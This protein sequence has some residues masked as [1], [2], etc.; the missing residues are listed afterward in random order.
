MFDTTN[1]VMALCVAG[2]EAEGEPAKARALFEQA[3]AARKG[4]FDA[5][6]AAHFLAR[7]Q[8]TPADTLHW[9][10]VALEHADA[11]RD[12]RV[13][14]L[15]PSLCLNLGDSLLA[16]GRE[17]EA[18]ALVERAESAVA[19]LPTD[20]YGMMVRGGIERL[21]ARVDAAVPEFRQGL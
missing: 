19:A 12:D 17:S 7:Q 13:A 1:P 21:R 18:L 8:P 2:M 6:V 5:S 14:T 20:G 10:T 11:L 3:W 4:D 16:A 9:N 15:L